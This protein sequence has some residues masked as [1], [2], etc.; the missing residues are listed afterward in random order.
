MPLADRVASILAGPA[1]RVLDTPIRETVDAV[2]RDRGYAAPAEI[3]ALRSDARDLRARLTALQTRVDDLAAQLE[4][5]HTAL[6]DARATQDPRVDELTAQ[7]STLR[8]RVKE[9]E[10]LTSADAGR[11]RP[12]A[13]Q[14][15]ATALPPRALASCKVDD[16]GQPVRSKGFC[17][18]HYQQWR[19]GTLPGFVGADGSATLH[20]G[21]TVTVSDSHAG[22]P[23]ARDAAGTLRVDGQP[24]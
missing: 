18:A 13:P 4:A 17:S 3:D 24:V 23:I 22:A 9:L 5:A 6:R 2:L 8:A 11:D 20:D 19:R 7:V 14:D 12:P 16:C 15:V 1:S 21:S 10:A